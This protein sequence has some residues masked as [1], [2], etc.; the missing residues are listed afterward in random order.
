VFTLLLFSPFVSESS[1]IAQKI[2]SAH[3]KLTLS[4]FRLQN[5]HEGSSSLKR[6]KGISPN[7]DCGHAENKFDVKVKGT[8]T[9]PTNVNNR[10]QVI[11]STMC[12]TVSLLTLLPN[13]SNAA[14]TANEAIRKS[15]SKLPGYGPPDIYFPPSLLGR[16]RVTRTILSDDDDPLL[17]RLSFPLN[18]VYDIRFIP[19]DGESEDNP[20]AVVQDRKF[21]EESYYNA[22]RL[23]IESFGLD[24][25]KGQGELYNIPQIRTTDWN[26][27]NPNVLTISYVDGSNLEIKVT[28]RSAE[29]DQKEGT[30][31]GSEY[32]RVTT[33]SNT[34]NTK[35]PSNVPSISSSRVLSKWRSSV[36]ESQLNKMKVEGIE[37]VYSDGISGDPM[38]TTIGNSNT[39]PRLISKSRLSLEKI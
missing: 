36:D 18:L 21:N 31:F 35:I 15:A 6:F 12:K 39:K 4:G 9:L 28:K 10:R 11:L 33:T 22:K 20:T 26:A 2:S 38:M 27:S 25:D 1:F 13:N 19:V 16:W 32:R 8:V 17:S 30:I 29:L 37:L 24:K 14:Q 34:S 5:K 23:K 7:D 3:L